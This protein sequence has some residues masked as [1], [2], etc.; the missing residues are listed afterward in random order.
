MTKGEEVIGRPSLMSD[1]MA[2]CSVV[3]RPIYLAYGFW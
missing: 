3:R 1:V 2:S